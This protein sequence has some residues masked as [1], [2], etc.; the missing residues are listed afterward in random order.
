MACTPIRPPRPKGNNDDLSCIA[1]FRRYQLSAALPSPSTRRRGWCRTALLAPAPEGQVNLLAMGDWGE[2]KP[3]QTQVA[4][5][6]A[7]YA[8]GT[9]R[10]FQ[11]MLLAGDNFYVP[12]PAWTIRNGRRCSSRCTT[13]HARHAVLCALG[14]HDYDGNK[15]AIEMDYARQH[16]ES[17]WKLPDRWYRID[18][19]ARISRW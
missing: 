3:A 12:L 9:T 10:P 6:L 5:A 2:G 17:R 19:A 13:R 16:P 14:N 15:V 18:L 4:H 11:G 8:A 1:I 7:D